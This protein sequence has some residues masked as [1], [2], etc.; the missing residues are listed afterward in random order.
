MH[1]PSAGRAVRLLAVPALLA[2]VATCVPGGAF[3]AP[4]T[5]GWVSYTKGLEI[6]GLSSL[7]IT[8]K[9]PETM[10]ASVLGQGIR[11]SDDQG[12]TWKPLRNGLDPMRS[13]RDHY[14]ITLDPKDDKTLYV[15]WLGRIFKSTDGGARF[16]ASG[17]GTIT[18]SLNRARQKELIVGV[19]VDPS[20]TQRL[21]A[22][23]RTENFYGGLFESE[24]GGKK[25]DQ[26]G[27]TGTRTDLQAS[28][29]GHD[30]WPIAI[31]SRSDKP[32]VVGGAAGSCWVSTDRGRHFKR[33]D[34]LGAGIHEAFDMTPIH[35]SEILLA[36]SRGLWRSRD[37]GEKWG[38]APVLAGPCIS[39]DTDPNQSSR[40]YAIIRGAGLFRS[41]D[42]KKWDGPK[43]MVPC[44]P[45]AVVC[46]PKTKGVVYLT[47]LTTNLWEST[48]KGENFN[49]VATS[50]PAAVPAILRVAAHPA[51]PNVLMA[52][53]E[54]GTVF[55]SQD[56]G[57]SWTKT[58]N[59][60]SP[61][62][63]LIGD[64]TSPN[65]WLA[66]GQGLFRSEDLGAS[67]KQVAVPKD[68]EDRIVTASREPDGSVAL[69]WE[70]D[71][72]IE[73][74]KNGGAAVDKTLARPVAAKNVWA[75]AFAVDAKNPQHLLVAM[76]EMD[77]PWSKDQKDGGAYESTD[78]GATWA[79]LDAG[80]V[81]VE[82][83]NHGAI[84]AIDPLDGTLYYGAEGAGLWKRG[85]G[86]VPT[87]P[88]EDVTPAAIQKP[89][90]F[91]AFT[92]AFVP[93]GAGGPRTEIVLQAEGMNTEI[94]Q[95]LRTTDAGKTWTVMGEP[96]SN[97]LGS[98]AVD[99]AI[100][101]RYLAGDMSGD[102][103]VLI[104]EPTGTAPT[105]SGGAPP[106]PTGP[107]V[108]PAPTDKPPKELL[109][110]TGG[111][112]KTGRVWDLFVGKE[113]AQL[114]GHKDGILRILLSHDESRLYTASA[115]R[116]IG[117]WDSRTGAQ[118]SSIEGHGQPVHSL[119][120]SPNG[121]RLYAGDAEWRIYVWDTATGKALAKYENHTGTVTSLALSPDGSRL[122]SGSQDKSI[123][124][125]DTS[126][127][128]IV[129][130]IKSLP[131]EVLALA[132]SPKG[133]K[134][135]AGSQGDGT[136]RVFDAAT[137]APAGT[138]ASGLAYV[139]CLAL[140]PDGAL[141]YAAGN[142][143]E[144]VAISTSDGKVVT[145]HAGSADDVLCVDVSHDGAWLVAGGADG[146]VHMWHK[147]SPVASWTSTG[148]HQASA[149]KAV[150]AITLSFDVAAAGDGGGPK[151]PPT[152]PAP[153][154]PAMG[155]AP[156]PT[157][158]PPAMGSDKPPPEPAM[159]TTPPPTPPPVVPP[160]P[161]PPAMGK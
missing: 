40:V 33:N 46:H 148:G 143:K 138:W 84:A 156:P 25:W 72:R 152:P 151:K 26:I 125:W 96:N 32:V 16:T 3:A 63:T 54:H 127:G 118:K 6:R 58:G 78:G 19:V 112:D 153:P 157:P 13:M 146:I 130:A 147:G 161:P 17:A 28:G 42:F 20:K 80:L 49:P 131:S 102:R 108:P 22:G 149:Q 113:L 117:V 62:T 145:K 83:A 158:P 104:Y 57:V 29:L 76:R 68:P 90:A 142:G 126:N 7:R 150:Y 2:L 87:F 41:E 88:W 50:L 107:V 38:K 30:A 123:L 52:I 109:A 60:G 98:L 77:E 159:G 35:G 91:H 44:D 36:E 45:N 111:A 18:F 92:M 14:E 43:Q 110:Y 93:P 9:M 21:L 139:T 135:Y 56:R 144:V 51:N 121:Q 12:K 129:V 136:V 122:Y 48:D 106:A 4:A 137:G 86:V 95:V 53:E 73:I 99:P 133:E 27:G 69:L 100:P 61:V 11:R 66:A 34:P 74:S 64:A 103:G 75:S 23:T 10:Y 155:G 160:T 154:E 114:S 89:I 140:S 120:L 116:T 31:D 82:G 8:E 115:D 59:L 97:R 24:D 15:V 141:L 124:V 132:L 101:G 5:P 79:H 94:R 37:A 65:T 85:A 1:Q 47:S 70:R 39:V 134:L 71:G 119:A 105:A 81:G 128:A 67:W 55:L